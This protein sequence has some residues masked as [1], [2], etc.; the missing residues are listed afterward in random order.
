[1]A[2]TTPLPGPV[3]TTPAAV[4]EPPPPAPPEPVFADETL[5]HTVDVGADAL[6]S[7]PVA[8]PAPPPEPAPAPQ[9]EPVTAPIAALAPEPEID[10]ARLAKPA[11]KAD[12]KH[13]KVRSSVDIMAELESLR[14][15]ATAA[16]AKSAKKEPSA[17]EL[18]LA[19]SRPKRD[20]H[21]TVSLAVAPGVLPK[22]KNLRFTVSFEND[23][24]VVQT[25]EQKVELG[26]TADVGSL[27]VNVKFDI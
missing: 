23:D 12:V 17:T 5:A 18:I 7:L 26:D 6:S 22:S 9:P 16:P 15:R 2:G 20:V 27:S 19:A 25:Q 11:K 1:V 10:F 4:I 13:V 3:F 8:E 24:G 14:K 21:K